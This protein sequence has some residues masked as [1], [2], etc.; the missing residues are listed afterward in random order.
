MYI[1]QSCC[2]LSTPLVGALAQKIRKMKY[3][4]TNLYLKI[5]QLLFMACDTNL[6]ILYH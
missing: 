6:H 5:K 1:F 3:K 2:T 4:C